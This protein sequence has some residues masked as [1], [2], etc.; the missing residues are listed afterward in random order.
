[1][2]KQNTEL[3][4]EN[5]RLRKKV[6]DV[7]NFQPGNNSSNTGNT[8][9]NNDSGA[10]YGTFGNYAMMGTGDAAGLGASIDP[11]LDAGAEE[12]L[13]GAV[14]QSEGEKKNT[15]PL[16]TD[17]IRESLTQVGERVESME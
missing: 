13:L 7:M 8:N 3:L 15:P 4:Q 17:A 16:D 2:K 5:D 9:G 6:E 12:R 10:N 14:G 11:T 1:L